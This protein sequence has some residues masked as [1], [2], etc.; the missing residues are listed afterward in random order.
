MTAGLVRDGLNKLDSFLSFLERF[1]VLK[2]KLTFKTFF[3][4]LLQYDNVVTHPSSELP[5][6]K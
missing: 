1:S 5:T 6:G 2:F 3:D 4:S